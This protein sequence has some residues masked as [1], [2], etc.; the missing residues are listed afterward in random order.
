MKFTL[1]ILRYFFSVLTVLL[2]T[3]FE[4]QA[5][6]FEPLQ[7]P[8]MVCSPLTNVNIS[9][10]IGPNDCPALHNCEIEV[11]VWDITACSIDNQPIVTQAYSYNNSISWSNLSITGPYMRVCVRIKP[12][13][14]CHET[15]YPHCRCQ[16]VGDLNVTWDVC[17]P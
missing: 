13:T 8:S 4:S 15:F 10:T 3:Q 2:L 16:P 7:E 1:I 5:E 11:A 14:S 12:G 6:S 17:N 9:V